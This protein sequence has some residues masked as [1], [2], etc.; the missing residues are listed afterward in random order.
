MNQKHK[1]KQKELKNTQK[2]ERDSNEIEIRR[3]VLENNTHEVIED[4]K[5][6]RITAWRKSQAKFF[7]N[8]IYNI[9]SCGILH[10]VSLFHPNLY[11][12]LYCDPSPGSECDFFLVENVYGKFTLCPIICKKK[13]HNKLNMNEEGKDNSA[14]NDGKRPELDLSK[15]LTYSFV[16]KSNVYE[17]DEKKEEI[18][19][20][21][22]DLSKLT[23]KGI[24]DF[25]LDGLGTRSMVNK[26]RERYGKNEY[27]FDVK[28]LF[29]FFLNNEIPSYAI[30]IFICI[31]Q[32]V[33]FPDY[34]ILIGK[35]GFV[36][37]FIAIQLINIKVTIINK[38]KKELTLDGNETKIRVKRNYLLK[39]LEESDEFFKEIEPEEILPGDIIFL[40]AN[41]FVPCD[42]LIMEGECIASESNLTG[43]LDIHKKTFLKDNND[44]FNYKNANINILYHGMKIIKT[45]SKINDNYISVL[46]INIGP[47]TYKANQYSNIFYFLERKKE[48]NYVYNL[49]GERKV[50]FYYIIIAICVSIIYL[51]ILSSIF[52][53]EIDQEGFKKLLLK[54][55][56]GCFCEC[57]M[58]PYFLNLSFMILLGIFR[59]QGNDIICF[60]KSRLINCGKINTIIFNKTGTLSK[61]HLE[62]NGYH[63]PNLNMQKN[64]HITYNNYT[65]SQSK[66]MNV[67]L[68]NYY[69]EYLELKEKSINNK[70]HVSFLA[71]NKLNNKFESQLTLF[72]ECLLCCNNVEKFGIDLFGSRIET[73]L[74]NDMKWDIKQ[75]DINNNEKEKGKNIEKNSIRYDNSNYYM[76]QKKIFDIFPKN[77]YKLSESSKKTSNKTAE[78][79]LFEPLVASEKPKSI[80]KAKNNLINSLEDSQIISDIQNSSNNSYKLRIYKKFLTN[81]SLSHSAI[82]YN[83]IKE[84]L[85]FM[86]RGYPEDIID[87]CQKNS[88]PDDLEEIV[89]IYR[90]NGLIVLVCATK[91]L[92]IEDY[93]D[94]EEIDYYM[95]DLIFCGFITLKNKI[96]DS[97][98][99]SIEQIKEFKCHMVISSA[100]N[101]Y[102]CLSTGFNSGIIDNN[103]IF[104]FDKQ[105]KLNKLSIKKIY[106]TRTF[107]K[108][109]ENK[110]E[111]KANDKV[112]KFSKL[113][114]NI[115]F[116]MKKTDISSKKLKLAKIQNNEDLINHEGGNNLK[117]KNTLISS[118]H[119]KVEDLSEV[120]K[121]NDISNSKITELNNANRNIADLNL[122][123]IESSKKVEKLNFPERFPKSKTNLAKNKSQ[124]EET[125]IQQDNKNLTFFKEV[126]YYHGIFEDFEDL[127]DGIYLISSA[128]FNF[129]YNN[130]TYKG[131]KYILDKIFKKSKIFFNM[132]SLDKSHLIDYF[133]ESGDNI[134]CS[135]GECDSDLDAIISS[136]VG[137]SLKN[138]P[139][140][141]MILCHFYSVKKDIIS[142]KKIITIGRLLYENS[143]LLEIVSFSCALSINFYLIGCLIKNLSIKDFLSNQL[144]FLD[145]EFLIIEMFSFAGSPK[146]KTNMIKSKSLLNIYYVLQLI[147]SLMFKMISIYML[148]SLYKNDV[149]LSIE[150][151]HHEYICFLFIL[152]VEFIINCIFI[153]NHISFYREPPFS[154]ITLVVSSLVILIY[155]ILL[156]C[157][158]SSNFKSDFLGL[159]NFAYSENLMDTYSDQNR[160]YLTIIICFDF[161]G[162]FLFCSIFYIIFNCFTK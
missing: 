76:I 6:K 86:T 131:I 74:F 5:I 156:L 88:I 95:E 126:I 146:E 115:S 1:S 34:T 159:T 103:N 80:S 100:D 122:N 145:L 82:V 124:M 57:L 152:C 58:L 135:L 153:F 25:F 10:L 55:F 59:L 85:R 46:C 47:N 144:R 19:P 106:S 151:R 107:I 23:N 56:L 112:S 60:D 9:L 99:Y 32:N 117:R 65:T 52:K 119:S 40:K 148:E 3:R 138:P 81:G 38:Y 161:A 7:K 105:D 28:L 150:E 134:V 141:N 120:R 15:N 91:N 123:K 4:T 18:I 37:G 162:S 14:L 93:N 30:V 98:K 78:N 149:Q 137:V 22:M 84:E 31:I 27:I 79:N 67:Q 158:N 110:K 49:F 69:K 113:S 33:A 2:R 63:I 39:D 102:N 62:I 45:F 35:I 43:K 160:M 13:S 21:Y 48:Y 154:N 96:N 68:L 66:E 136:N 109:D 42:C 129:L 116:N 155:V 54:T 108:E 140:Q 128:A 133:R 125:N 20:V 90:R 83:Y 44:I 73:S 61:E 24:L 118:D 11:I 139:N 51:A 17:Y 8:F 127:K 94:N 130:R 147:A 97:V 77:Y 26:F 53:N 111:N 87:K 143:I 75:F 70:K 29:L 50:I 114:K 92:E 41:D 121:L 16:Y 64:G 36:I 142:L 132:S 72:L 12:K 101:E 104:V 71:F 157:F 89:S